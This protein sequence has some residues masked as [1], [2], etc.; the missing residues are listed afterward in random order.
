[1]SAAAACAPG[2]S[3][4]EAADNGKPA[5]RPPDAHSCPPPPAP[6]PPADAA[7]SSLPSSMDLLLQEPPDSSTSPC[8]ALPGSQEEVSGKEEG[9]VPAKKQKTPGS[10]KSEIIHTAE[11]GVPERVAVSAQRMFS[12]S[13]HFLLQVKTWFQ[14]Q[15][16]K[17]K[18]WQKSNWPKNSSS[19]PQKG[20]APA[21]YPGACSNYAQGYLV[22]TS[23]NLPVWGNQTWNNAGWSSPSWGSPSWNAQSWCP[24]AWSAPLPGFGEEALQPCLPFPQNFPASDLEAA[25]EAVGDSYKYLSTPQS[26]DLFLNYPTNPQPGDL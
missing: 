10:L 4:S 2:L 13:C 12:H 18:R 25:L 6:V 9:K 1:M 19:I 5:P 16:M 17:C 20:P 21:E 7:A 15:R 24:Q 3:D 22:N 8:I 23:G 14:N 11:P 26:L